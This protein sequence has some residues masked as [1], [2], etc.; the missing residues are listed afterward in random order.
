[1]R[2]NKAHLPYDNHERALKLLYSLDRK[3]WEVKVTT[4]I[5]SSG[6]ETLTVDEL[7]NKLKSTEIDYQTQ[8][9]LKNPSAPTMV[10]DS[11]NG[12][13]SLANP[14]QMSF[15]L[16]SLVSVS[17]EQLEVLGDDEL[18]LIISRF[19]RFHNN[20][21][22][23]WWGGGPKEGCYGY[24]DPDHLVAHYPKMNKH[25]SDKYDSSKCKDKR[26]YT[27][28]YKSKGGFDK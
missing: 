14:S 28:K 20:R 5:E 23:H 27:S 25:S 18:V 22:N 12:S 1:M 16:S 6:Y 11:G 9:K 19:S 8:A 26:E 3:V 15:A 4:I 7:F 13:S 21:L 10:L 17:E 24:G 2:G